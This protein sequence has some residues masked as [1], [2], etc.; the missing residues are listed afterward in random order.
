MS[1]KRSATG[2]LLII[3][4]AALVAGVA[5]WT[6]KLA[7]LD[8]TYF[9]FLSRW[10]L[11]D[12][13]DDIAIVAV[14]EASIARLGAWPWS[15]AI[16]ARLLSKLK[17]ADAVIF[18][19][20]FS[21]RQSPSVVSA[22]TD[23][24]DVFAAAI[25]QAGNVVLPLFI[26]EQQFRGLKNEVLPHPMFAKRAASLGHVQVDSDIDGI[27]RGVYLL[28][29]LGSAYWPHLAKALSVFLAE[30]SPQGKDDSL[31]AVDPYRIEKADFT[32]IRYVGLS[33]IHI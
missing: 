11:L 20:I 4:L 10:Q 13:P 14:D 18:D 25:A 33:L 8:N 7:S 29:G 2:P 1:V 26:E 21:E 28:Q 19:V 3:M 24:D 12:Y 5:S 27:T 32:R 9:D 17:T 30:S 31:D 22:I 23:D 16:H 15:R 6:D